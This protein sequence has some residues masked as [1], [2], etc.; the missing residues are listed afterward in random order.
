MGTGESRDFMSEVSKLPRTDAQRWDSPRSPAPHAAGIGFGRRRGGV[1]RRTSRG[2]LC[3]AVRAGRAR[4]GAGGSAAESG[5]L[6]PANR[7]GKA[8]TFQCV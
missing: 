1:I 4:V 6:I 5:G 7:G 3:A 2:G 8:D